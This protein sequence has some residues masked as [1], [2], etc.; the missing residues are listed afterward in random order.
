MDFI[1]RAASARQSHTRAMSYHPHNG[2]GR[3]M[4]TQTCTRDQRHSPKPSA[5]PPLGAFPGKCST[6]SCVSVIVPAYNAAAHIRHSLRSACEQSYEELEIIVVDDGSTDNTGE[7]IRNEFPEVHYIRQ[8]NGGVSV[9][10]NTGIQAAKGDFLAFLDADDIWHPQKAEAQVR[11]FERYP[12]A[13]LSRTVVLHGRRPQDFLVP[14]FHHSH[15]LPRHH[16]DRDFSISFRT[17]FFATS[18]VMVRRAAALE[19]GGFSPSLRVAE[20]VDFFLRVLSRAPQVAVI[21]VPAL[22]KVDV[23]GSLGHDSV[24]GYWALLSVYERFLASKQLP[25][26]LVDTRT[27]REVFARLWASQAGAL[28]RQGDLRAGYRAL[29]RSVRHAPTMLALRIAGAMARQLV[30]SHSE[31]CVER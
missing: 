29:L 1:A 17:P 9:A 4:H 10:R 16:I 27:A 2:T 31:T 8:A 20:D 25:E 13:V 14:L 26:G 18:T 6:M 23:V 24:E 5:A 19:A 28:A 11:L 30:R 15:D 12:A 3:S 22:F 7:I 21:D